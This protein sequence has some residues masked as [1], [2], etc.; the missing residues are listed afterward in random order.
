MAQLL[1]ASRFAPKEAILA[2]CLLFA[3]VSAPL[4]RAFAS[5]SE[6]LVLGRGDRVW[7]PGDPATH[8]SIVAFGT[9]K[10]QRLRPES[11]VI[12]A[13]FNPGESVADALVVARGKMPACAVAQSPVVELLRVPAEPVLAAAKRD[14]LLAEALHLAVSRQVRWLH[15]KIEVV[16]MG[17]VSERIATF[18]L[19]H[20][21]QLGL[22]ETCNNVELGFAPT[23]VELASMIEA[24]PETVTR[25]L[26]KLARDGVVTIG[27]STIAIHDIAALR[28]LVPHE[29]SGE[30]A[31]T[32]DDASAVA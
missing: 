4:V 14:P 7:L 24:R 9:V 18:V 2:G 25:A 1:H 16:T 22:P 8:F 3:G 17:S 21:E 6:R 15:T 30:S 23:R 19:R 20:V 27:K 29:L 5:A 11:P 26:G 13:F 31:R 10:L 32:H 28:A 12:L